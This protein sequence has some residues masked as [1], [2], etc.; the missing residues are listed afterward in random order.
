M[1][2][3]MVMNEYFAK[4][5]GLSISTQRF[6]EELKKLGHDVKILSGNKN[7]ISEFSLNE[8]KI[9][10]FQK[11]IDKQG[12]SFAKI[13][14]EII[15]KAIDWADII[16][17][18]DPFFLSSYAGKRAKKI[19]KPCVGTFHVYPEN[20]TSSVNLFWCKPLNNFFMNLFKKHIYDYCSHVQCPTVAIKERL[21]QYKYKS[22]LV[23]ISNGILKNQISETKTENNSDLFKILS[24]GRYS[25]EKRQD[26]IFKAVNKSKYKDK[27]QI[28]LAGKGP[29]YNKYLKLS[30]IL[31]NKTIFKFMP[32]EELKKC[33]DESDLYIHCANV[34]V[35]GMSCMESFAKGLVP[36]IANS[37]LSSTKIYALTENN[38]FNENDIIDLKNKIEYF[39]ENKQ[40]KI[41]LSKKY[42]E[43]SK[44]LVIENQVQKLVEMYEQALNLNN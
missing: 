22:N 40:E 31:P 9:P 2:I 42:I 34:E 23:V 15:N 37:E 39:I 10:I 24:I 4:G 18:Q 17:L 8:L 12:F 33:I 26:L 7:G 29:L 5:N 28:T 30:K 27:I 32:Q 11:I 44:E 13:D 1:K 43:F 38:I 41:N 36:I 14:K 6:V 19:N 20:L 35:E 25:K 21:E 16:H 3:L